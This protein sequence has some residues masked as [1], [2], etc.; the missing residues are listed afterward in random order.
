MEKRT[1]I[2]ILLQLPCNKS[3]KKVASRKKNV[4]EC[5]KILWDKYTLT[6]EIYSNGAGKLIYPQ[7]NEPFTDS[8]VSY[9]DK[10][11]SWIKKDT[12]EQEEKVFKALFK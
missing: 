1:D 3:V 10:N 8:S 4:T 5:F 12:K 11:G 2:Q 9:F 6:L 7:R